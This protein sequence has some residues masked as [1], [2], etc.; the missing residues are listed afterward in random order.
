MVAIHLSWKWSISFHLDSLRW[1][2]FITERERESSQSIARR[3]KNYLSYLEVNL[4]DWLPLA[5]LLKF[6]PKVQKKHKEVTLIKYERHILR[7]F[8][9]EF[10]VWVPWFM[11]LPV[12]RFHLSWVFCGCWENSLAVLVIWK[13]LALTRCLCYSTCIWSSVLWGISVAYLCY[14]IPH[15]FSS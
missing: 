7:H 9:I 3:N 2:A 1:T 6:Y 8:V 10:L 15:R 5:L 12:M 11:K 4:K 13:P 14:F